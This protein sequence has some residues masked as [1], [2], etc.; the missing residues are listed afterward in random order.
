VLCGLVI[1]GCGHASRSSQPTT[2]ATTTS[3]G[4]TSAGT[5]TVGAPT[6]ATVRVYLLRDG[7]V[8]PVARSVSTP[9][10]ATAALT[11]LAAGPTAQE[12]AQGYTSAAG[13]APT[14]V[15]IA[16][17]IATLDV[18]VMTHAGLAQVVYTLTQFPTVR[19]VQ[20]TRSIGDSQPLTRSDFE[21]VT[22]SILVESP[23]PGETVTSPLRVAGTAN[24]FEATFD[25]EVRNSSGVRV[26]WRFVT[27]TSGSG[28]RGTFD[29]TI[30]FPHTGGPITLV[31]YEPSAENGKPIHVVRIPLKEG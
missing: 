9:A 21:N 12:S 31:A 6:Q 20:G 24:T 28:T 5:T 13:N 25:L 11:Q 27:A 26:A 30:S 23:L 19:G 16:N 2:Q 4:T 7:K 14:R 10:V 17:G 8:A 1:A 29:A 18:P 22:P 3:A 15:T